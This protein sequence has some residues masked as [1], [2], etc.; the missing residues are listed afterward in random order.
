MKKLNLFFLIVIS[1]HNVLFSMENKQKDLLIQYSDSMN[2]RWKVDKE[3]QFYVDDQ[4]QK[5]KKD[6]AI[7]SVFFNKSGTKIKAWSMPDDYIYRWSRIDGKELRKVPF[8]CSSSSKSGSSDESSSE[9]GI[10][11]ISGGEIFHSTDNE[12]ESLWLNSLFSRLKHLEID[13][14][15]G[16]MAVWNREN[17]IVYV[18]DRVAKKEVAQL[19]HKNE[20]N[21]VALSGLSGT[22]LTSSDC[23]MCV[24]DGMTGKEL[25]QVICDRN[26]TSASFNAKETEIVFVTDDDK[27]RV[28]V[29]D[30][31]TS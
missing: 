11:R 30:D 19:V 5:L 12:K 18:W 20:I 14:S 24:W 23:T 22:I 3:I 6:H 4:E 9:V 15:G 17:P 13:E 2:Q 21:L 10:T 1:N 27:I 7:G 8:D 31:L 26:V 29:K 25:L 28:L 16:F